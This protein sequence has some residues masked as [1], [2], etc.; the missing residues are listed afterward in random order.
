MN[1]KPTPRASKKAAIAAMDLA[2][3]GPPAA[4]LLGHIRQLIQDSQRAAAVN[5]SLT[6]LYWRIGRRI[7]EDVLASKRAGYGEEIVAALSRQLVADFGRGLEVKN[8]HRMVQ[9]AQAFADE[10][11]VATLWRHLSWLHFR[12]LLPLKPPLQCEF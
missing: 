1:K 9:F 11:I 4:G 3:G 5:I 2:T 7:R 12:K 8:L 6:M 10:E